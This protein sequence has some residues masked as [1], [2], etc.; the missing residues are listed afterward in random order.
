MS[1]NIYILSASLSGDAADQKITDLISLIDDDEL[2]L[3]CGELNDLKYRLGLDTQL[4]PAMD[5]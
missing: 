2:N 4:A 1:T 5:W 3:I